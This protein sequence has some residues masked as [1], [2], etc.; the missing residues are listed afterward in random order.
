[1]HPTP[2]PAAP[3]AVPFSSLTPCSR[4]GPAPPACSPAWS[5]ILCDAP[6][7]TCPRSMCGPGVT[8][9]GASWP[10]A[11]STSGRSLSQRSTCRPEPSSGL[12]SC[13]PSPPP[14]PAC[15]PTPPL[16]PVLVW[17]DRREGRAGRHDQT[18]AAAW[19]ND[20]RAR[21]SQAGRVP[22]ASKPHFNLVGILV[23]CELIYYNLVR[24]TN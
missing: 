24:L 19:Q 21:L 13:C 20:V 18:T 5:A 7:M 15:Q 10:P 3:A 8:K 14:L 17:P 9:Q 22:A 4:H 6:A 2:P 11:S 1:V 12:I 23:Y 16:P